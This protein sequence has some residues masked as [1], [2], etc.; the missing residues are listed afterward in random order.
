MLSQPIWKD[1]FNVTFSP[2]SVSE[3]TP[4]AAPDG[5]MPDLFG[6]V[7]VPARV[8]QPPA[9]ARALTTSAISG[10]ISSAS[11]RSAALTQ[12]LVSRLKPRLDMAGSTLFK[13][14]WK[15]S[16]TPSGR[17]V[18]RLAASGHRTSGKGFT[19]WPT[20]NAMEGGQTSR[21][22]VERGREGIRQAHGEIGA[23][24]GDTGSPTS[25]VADTMLARG[26][27]WRQSAQSVSIENRASNIV[28]DTANDGHTT[29]DGLRTSAQSSVAPEQDGIGK[30]AGSGD[31][32]ELGDTQHAGS[33]GRIRPGDMELHGGSAAHG[34]AATTG[35]WGN[36]EWLPCRDG[37]SRPVEPGV[38]PLAHGAPA[39]VGR[40]RGYGNAIV[41]PQAQ[42]FIEA[43]LES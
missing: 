4:C 20:P 38:A 33:Q 27:D 12:S 24:G 23:S 19:S 18:F 35:F 26:K 7:V 5:P 16:N 11:S 14:T 6:Q 15:E 31:A 30:S 22:T 17:L 1:L 41:S 8:S 25:I 32:D 40:L 39:R 9:K 29:A 2:V 42:A 36:A 43:Y 37:K 28:A 3:A 13:M 21:E 34:P 10:P